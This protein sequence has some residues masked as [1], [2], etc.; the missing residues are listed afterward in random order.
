M[1]DLLVPTEL[2]LSGLPHSLS[3]LFFSNIHPCSLKKIHVNQQKIGSDKKNQ[4]YKHNQLIHNINKFMLLLT[5]FLLYCIPY[6]CVNPKLYFYPRIES[7]STGF[8]IY[9]NHVCQICDFRMHHLSILRYL[10]CQ[11]HLLAFTTNIWYM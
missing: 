10:D 1:H 5:V 7:Q 4:V 2:Q 8:F 11:K 6:A 3:I 9:E